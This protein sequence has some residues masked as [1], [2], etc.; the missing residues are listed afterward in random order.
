MSIYT[1]VCGLTEPENTRM[2]V[3]AGVDAI[4]L[5]FYP[6]SKRYISPDSAI[7]LRNGISNHVDVVGVFVNAA[8]EDVINIAT[9]V[10]L[11]AVQFHGDESAVEIKQVQDRCPSAKIL[12]AFR[13]SKDNLNQTI[14]E[15]RALKDAG[16]KL[17]AVL[18]DAFVSGEFG[19]TGHQLDH[20]LIRQLPVEWPP[21]IV[22][23]GL[24]ADNVA[25]CIQ[26]VR[27]WGV[28]VASGVESK[29]GMKDADKTRQFITAAK[30][31]L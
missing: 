31:A 16:V 1:K 20:E 21:L 27:P 5:N 8:R 29:P 2:V 23:G 10:R 12:R 7:T 14:D 22:A 3:D 19:G 18:V 11:S 15:V 25:N 28:D 17:S 6:K 4:G 26:T 9:A 30:N 24:T 13:L